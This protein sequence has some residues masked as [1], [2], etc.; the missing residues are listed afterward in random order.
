MENIDQTKPVSGDMTEEDMLEGEETEQEAP[1]LSDRDALCRKAK[2]ASVYARYLLPCIT[3]ALLLAFSFFDWIYFYMGGIRMKMSLFDFYRNTLTRAHTYLAG[4]TNA[5][6]D[7]FYGLLSAGAVVG[8]L[9]FVLGLFFALYAAITAC[10]ALGTE[11]DS[12]G[13]NRMKV[14]FKIAFPNRIS[15]FLSHLLLVVPVLFPEYFSAIG[16]RFILIGGKSTVF[17]DVNVVLI[18]VGILLLITLALA[19]L[20]PRWERQQDMNMFLI[21]HPGED[22]SETEDD[23]EI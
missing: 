7:W 15:L 10:R 23:T 11:Q 13:C 5:Q 14:L 12:E 8:I 19:L 22:D 4:T 16:K 6:S 20:I 17:V 3:A 1:R 18:L 9:I 2:R 21:R